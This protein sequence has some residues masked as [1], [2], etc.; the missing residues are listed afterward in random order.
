MVHLVESNKIPYS[1]LVW[2]GP[3]PKHLL[4]TKVSRLMVSEI[5]EQFIGNINPSVNQFGFKCTYFSVNV[6]LFTKILD[7]ITNLHYGIIVSYRQIQYLPFTNEWDI[8]YSE[9]QMHEG[10]PISYAY[11]FTKKGDKNGFWEK[12]NI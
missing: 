3:V 5:S 1:Y 4:D 6:G 11:K 12:Y 8:E 10:A 7:R 2:D 9:K